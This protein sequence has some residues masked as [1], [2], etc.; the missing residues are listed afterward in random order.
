MI[1]RILKTF[2]DYKTGELNYYVGK[3]T[4]YKMDS[5]DDF[6]HWIKQNWEQLSL[7]NKVFE[8]LVIN[9]GDFKTKLIQIFI[10]HDCQHIEYEEA[11]KSS[12][13]LVESFSI[14]SYY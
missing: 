2:R 12:T 9:V 8:M 10:K 1:L 5:V 11:L 14:K 6:Y 3:H 4:D 7:G 13:A